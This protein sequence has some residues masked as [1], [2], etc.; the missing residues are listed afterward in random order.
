MINR[1][2]SWRLFLVIS[3]VFVS[4]IL[5]A[6]LARHLWIEELKKFPANQLATEFINNH[7]S[8][9]EE[10]VNFTLKKDKIKGEFIYDQQSGFGSLS[11]V[12]ITPDQKKH[13]VKIHF[14]YQK[15]SG[16]FIDWAYLENAQKNI[17]NLNTAQQWYLKAKDAL[18]NGRLKTAAKYCEKIG[19]VSPSDRRAIL[20]LAQKRHF[21]NKT[22]EAINLLY[23]AH[24][25]NPQD[26]RLTLL[27]ADFLAHENEGHLAQ[28]Y[29][30]KAF[31]EQKQP[32]AALKLAEIFIKKKDIKTAKKWLDQELVKNNPSYYTDYLLGLYYWHTNQENEAIRQYHTAL[33]KN[34]NF[35]NAYFA[36]ARV[37]IKR[38]HTQ[39]AVFYFEKGIQKKPR[40]ALKSRYELLDYLRKKNATEEAL[41]HA[42]KIILYHPNEVPAFVFL[43]FNYHKINAIKKSN[44]YWS[45]ANKV[46]KR[47]A[48]ELLKI[49]NQKGV[50]LSLFY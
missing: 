19:Q 12:L 4:L 6:F 46:D 7:P 30:E 35:A 42:K 18:E 23:Q 28:Q 13:L 50:D 34:A 40:H 22:D 25:K 37:S 26:P 20:C 39:R 45:R 10:L 2:E 5:L 14:S 49:W 11:S 43:A 38:N 17:I 1:I 24:K 9:R 3:V 29:Y 32:L 47:Y 33:D 41:Y 16:W 8:I 15:G 48:T 31:Y 21:E 27:L 36:L 44:Q